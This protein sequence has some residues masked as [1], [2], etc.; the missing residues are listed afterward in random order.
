MRVAEENG[1]NLA[2]GEFIK[3]DEQ[4]VEKLDSYKKYTSKEKTVQH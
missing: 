2:T 1:L 3:P 4:E